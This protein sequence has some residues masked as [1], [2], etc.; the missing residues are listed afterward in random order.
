M[1][2]TKDALAYSAVNDMMSSHGLGL[3]IVVK[4]KSWF[5]KTCG[6]FLRPFNPDFMEHYTT[7]IPFLNTMY[8][9]ETWDLNW[10]TMAHESIHA[11]QAKQDGQLL[12]A[13][14]YMFPQCLGPLAI[15]SVGA[16]WWTPMLFALAF[17]V[18]FAPWPARWRVRYER[19]AYR[20]SG[21]MDAIQGYDVRQPMYLSYMLR[22]YTGWG[23]YKMSWGG[24]MMPIHVAADM[25][26]ADHL[27]TTDYIVGDDVSYEQSLVWAVKGA[28]EKSA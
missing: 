27:A 14:K 4:Q 3:K 8:V 21:A 15:L 24:D 26:Y 6:L 28:L 22:H 7:T 2:T 12:F 23:Y 18:A 11:L 9:P 5:M 10:R 1:S 19:E 16:I 13:L 25:I 17:L 20:V